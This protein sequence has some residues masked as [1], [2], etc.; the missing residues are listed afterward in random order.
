MKKRVTKAD[1]LLRASHP[2]DKTNEVF[3]RL[4]KIQCY[5]QFN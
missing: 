2:P 3:S 5:P 4:N 1:A